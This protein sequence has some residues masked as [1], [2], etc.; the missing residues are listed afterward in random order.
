MSS[1]GKCLCKLFHTKNNEFL[2]LQRRKIDRNSKRQYKQKLYG[3]VNMLTTDTEMAIKLEG[4]I[5]GPRI[6]S[7]IFPLAPADKRILGWLTR[8][9]SLIESY[10]SYMMMGPKC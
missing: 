3:Q 1:V 9:L 6:I 2:E 4:N 5:Y 7:S 10:R 8:G